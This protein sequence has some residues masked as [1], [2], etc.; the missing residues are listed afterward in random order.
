MLLVY[1]MLRQGP[2]MNTVLLIVGL[3]LLLRLRLLELVL[4]GLPERVQ[5]KV[6]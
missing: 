5:P 4:W 6:S 1:E 3:V 2:K